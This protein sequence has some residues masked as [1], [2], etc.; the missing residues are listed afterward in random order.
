MCARQDYK[1]PEAAI[2]KESRLQQQMHKYLVDIGVRE[3]NTSYPTPGPSV[4]P[5]ADEP[6]ISE[7]YLQYAMDD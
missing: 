7:K 5:T 1:P 2:T 3:K 6:T 4:A